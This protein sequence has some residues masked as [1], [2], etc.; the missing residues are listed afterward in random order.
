MKIAFVGAT[1][2]IGKEIAKQALQRQHQITALT[3][4]A[5]LPAELVGAQSVIADILDVAALS[6]VVRGHDVL[7]SAYG[8]ALNASET[9]SQVM[10]A[11]IAAARNAG[12]KRLM[13]V[14]G[15]GS[16][17]VAP[18]LQLVD[19]PNFPEAYKAVAL[20][21]RDALAILR[22]ATDLDWTFFAPAAM[23]GPGERKGHFRIGTDS[24]ITDNEGNSRIS[25]ADY[26]TAF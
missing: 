13:V 25:Y 11:L 23:I 24:L 26:A 21:H 2:N 14:G 22:N 6:T 9:S 20:A 15:A 1:G 10:S 8:P 18:D 16:L 12:I 19:T 3:R 7:I 5:E 4:R 17:F